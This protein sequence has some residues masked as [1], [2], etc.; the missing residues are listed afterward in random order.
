MQSSTFEIKNEIEKENNFHNCL[1]IKQMG[2]SF[3]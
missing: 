2:L 3:C 1:L